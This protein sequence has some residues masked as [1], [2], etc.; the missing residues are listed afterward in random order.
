MDRHA[1][2]LPAAHVWLDAVPQWQMT[3]VVWYSDELLAPWL[4]LPPT[5]LFSQT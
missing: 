1:W 3:I 4:E 2:L 5:E